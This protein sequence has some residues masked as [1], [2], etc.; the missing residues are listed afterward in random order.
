MLSES[1]N[2]ICF[3]VFKLE[4]EIVIVYFNVYL[5]FSTNYNFFF[6]VNAFVLIKK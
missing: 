3:I 2:G 1:L 6:H 5:I 4:Q